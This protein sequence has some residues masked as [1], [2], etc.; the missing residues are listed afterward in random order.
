MK[1]SRAFFSSII[2]LLRSYALVIAI[3]IGFSLFG[4][5]IAPYI[6][7]DGSDFYDLRTEFIPLCVAIL[8]GYIVA[9]IFALLKRG[10]DEYE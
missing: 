2:S 5:L 8:V 6:G 1:N 3:I 4:R 7:L 10:D 9:L